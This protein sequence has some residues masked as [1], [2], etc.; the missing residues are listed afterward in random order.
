MSLETSM[1]SSWGAGF[2][3]RGLIAIEHSPSLLFLY[4]I[5]VLYNR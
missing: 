4:R 5:A 2:P 3:A 1:S